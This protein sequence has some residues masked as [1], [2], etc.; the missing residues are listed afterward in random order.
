MFI[1][2]D[3]F[4][5]YTL[6]RHPQGE[7]IKRI[8]FAALRAV[9]PATAVA[10]FLEREGDLL[11][12][13]GRSYDLSRFRRVFLIGAGK[14]AAPMARAAARIIGDRL[15]GGMIITKQ[16]FL[17]ETAVS[18]SIPERIQVAEAAHPIPDE[19]GVIATRRIISLLR[20]AGQH[21]LV[22]A[23]I[24]GGGSALLTAPAEGIHLADIQI[25]TNLLLSCGASIDEINTLRKHLDEVKGGG[26]ARAAGGA[27]LLALVLSDVVGDPLDVIAS[28][29]TVADPTCFEDAYAIL[30]RYDLLDRAP[31]SILDRIQQGMQGQIA[32]TPKPGDALFERVHNLIVASNRHAV[33]A[34]L[35]EAEDCGFTAY[36]LS[37]YLQGEARQMGGFLGAIARQIHASGQPFKPPACIGM[38]GET[39]VTLHGD[40]LGGRNLETALGAVRAFDGLDN[41]M[42]V[43]LASDGDDG[44]TD[45]AGTVVSGDTLKRAQAQQLKPE[46][47]LARNDSYNFFGPLGDL[48]RTGPTQT[49]VNDLAFLFAFSG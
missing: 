37:T 3:S 11:F 48:I 22:I 12:A 49:N 8:L 33:Q 7:Q 17:R 44:P 23:L 47:F 41:L 26:L 14:A 39:T 2:K 42:L 46:D 38:G 6:D 31:A 19:R 32:D 10:R 13:G 20:S 45:A 1:S 40:G 28:G 21:D 15:S 36:L 24:S 18:G 9:D 35:Q 16:G 4:R 27:H 34:A 30:A 43:T 25:L 5:T 29:P